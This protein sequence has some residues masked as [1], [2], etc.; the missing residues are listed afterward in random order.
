MQSRTHASHQTEQ[1]VHDSKL[2]YSCVLSDLTALYRIHQPQARPAHQICP[3]GAPAGRPPAW[4]DKCMCCPLSSFLSFIDFLCDWPC[5]L[6]RHEY[7]PCKLATCQACRVAC[8][9]VV[10]I[11]S[12]TLLLLFDR[13]DVILRAH[14]QSDGC[15]PKP[16]KPMCTGLV[17]VAR[18]LETTF[19]R[20]V[21]VSISLSSFDVVEHVLCELAVVQRRNQRPQVGLSTGLFPAR[22]CRN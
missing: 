2:A 11:D 16:C 12:I 6:A 8:S 13:V 18:R 9:T 5:A 1:C 21:G 15:R 19:S 20:P 22:R 3:S 17:R 14:A 10:S 7:C 4:H